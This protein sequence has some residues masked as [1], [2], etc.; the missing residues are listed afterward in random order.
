MVLRCHV[1]YGFCQKLPLLVTGHPWHVAI[2]NADLTPEPTF[3][4]IDHHPRSRAQEQPRASRVLR[5]VLTRRIVEALAFCLPQ[6]RP[7]KRCAHELLQLSHG[8]HHRLR[9]C[10]VPA[11]SSRLTNAAWRRH[12]HIR[13]PL[14]HN[15]AAHTKPRNTS[16]PVTT[17]APGACRVLRAQEARARAD[18]SGGPSRV[19][20]DGKRPLE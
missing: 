4:H 19:G 12:S 20:R 13:S 10:C 17:T 16:R 18:K 14:S 1:I 2:P 6:Q 8:L 11:T 7:P 3:L 5:K 9:T 15:I